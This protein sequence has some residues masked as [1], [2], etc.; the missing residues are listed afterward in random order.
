MLDRCE[1]RDYAD[2]ARLGYV[3]RA[4]VTQLMNLCLLAPDIQQAILDA[5][6][7]SSVPE[8]YLRTAEREATWASQRIVVAELL[9][10]LTHK[11]HKSCNH[12]NSS[13]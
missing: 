10:H 5:Q 12:L 7:L 9:G 11:R 3:S 4:R 6:M 2:L 8:Q 13:V 1:V